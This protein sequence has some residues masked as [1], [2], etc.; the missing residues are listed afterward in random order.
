M[1]IYIDPYLYIYM[2]IYKYIYKCHRHE[3]G[4][5]KETT[6]FRVSVIFSIFGV[7]ASGCAD[8]LWWF[9]HA[10]AVVFRPK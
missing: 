1:Y 7:D 4:F 5:G 10:C 2:Y 9:F 8:K 6:M 3:K